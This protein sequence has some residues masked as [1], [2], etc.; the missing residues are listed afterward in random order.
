MS[1]QD[2][3]GDAALLSSQM[4]D[5]QQLIV[6]RIPNRKGF[7]LGLVQGTEYMALARF[8]GDGEAQAFM[9]WAA[10]KGLT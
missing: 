6:G 8:V 1:E 4:T 9:V 10:K 7:Y 3:S 5:E 2:F